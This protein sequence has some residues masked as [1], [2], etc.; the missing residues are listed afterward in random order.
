MLHKI[1][2]RLNTKDPKP[3]GFHLLSLAQNLRNQIDLIN[4]TGKD[5]DRR[6]APHDSYPYIRY[7]TFDSDG[8]AS[9]A[10]SDEQIADLANLVV[11]IRS[12]LKRKHG[13]LL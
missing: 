7:T 2:L 1:N 12:Y 8:W 11:R 6:T 4:V 13:F 3:G 9:P 5:G 10:T